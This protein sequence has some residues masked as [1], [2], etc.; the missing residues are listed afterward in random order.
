MQSTTTLPRNYASTD[1]HAAYPGSCFDFSDL[2]SFASLH[3]VDTFELDPEACPSTTPCSEAE[4][5]DNNAPLELTCSG[6]TSAASSLSSARS[7][8]ASSPSTIHVEQDDVIDRVIKKLQQYSLT[9][10]RAD[11]ELERK[12]SRSGMIGMRPVVVSEQDS[13]LW[14]KVWGSATAVRN[15][16][17]RRMRRNGM[18]AKVR[19]VSDGS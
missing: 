2:M 8:N 16:K 15:A 19:V 4:D 1:L 12:I 14:T 5:L 18:K 10:T 3:P 9:P 6:S 11:G 17:E 13:L 7:P